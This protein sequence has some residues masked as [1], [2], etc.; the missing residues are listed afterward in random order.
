MLI[1][2]RLFPPLLILALC[3]VVSNATSQ[4]S[5]TRDSGNPVLR[6]YSGEAIDPN[7]YLKLYT[8]GLFAD[9]L[10]NDSS[11][12]PYRM[13]FGS[14]SAAGESGYSI[15]HAISPNKRDWFYSSSNPVLTKGPD[16]SF[17]DVWVLDPDVIYD[18]TEFKMYYSAHDGANFYIGLATSPDGVRWMKSGLNPVL[19]PTSGAWD[20]VAATSAEVTFDGTSYQMIYTGFDGSTYAIGVATSADGL[21]WT[22]HALNPV[23][24]K[25]AL[26]S[27]DS[28]HAISCAMA[29]H[30]GVY[31]LFYQGET[32]GDL[33]LATSADGISWSKYGGNP[34]F[35]STGSF[36]NGIGY[37]AVIVKNGAFELWY[38]GLAGSEQ[39]GHASSPLEVLSVQDGASPVA[40]ELAQ[41]YPNPFN[42][43]TT[44]RYR[45]PSRSAV[46]LRVYSLLG[47]VVATVV[48]GLQDPGDHAVEWDAGSV[49]SG[50]YFCRLS[51]TD[52]GNVN[53]AST[54]VRKMMLL[55]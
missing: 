49:A 15:S 25:G 33:G 16:G 24:S 51:V 17:D 32:F 29:V 50:A 5:W 1:R 14:R 2:T 3:A 23:L 41:N 18:G 4:I 28:Q 31:Y 21:H 20:A 52:L 38:S 53:S 34:V 27:W 46:E 45:I 6:M 42:P 35:S 44:I 10:H 13:W 54:H 9:S 36:E 43:R 30:E 47:E 19:S 37:G 11:N 26:G 40:Y 22:K 55:K 8:V 7:A 48:D 12:I 39:I